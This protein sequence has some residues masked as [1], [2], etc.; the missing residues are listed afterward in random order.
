MESLHSESNILELDSYSDSEVNHDVGSDSDSEAE[1]NH[2]VL[3]PQ[4]AGNFSQEL[5]EEDKV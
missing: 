2:D 4:D 3:E 1:V 5:E